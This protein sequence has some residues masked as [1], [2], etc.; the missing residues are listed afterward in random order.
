MNDMW[1][2]EWLS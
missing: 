1:V 2:S